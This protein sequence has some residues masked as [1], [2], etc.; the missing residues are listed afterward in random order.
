MPRRDAENG[1]DRTM[2]RRTFVAGASALG[3]T[4]GALS[5]AA[6][7][8]SK[9]ETGK[10]PKDLSGGLPDSREYLF[11]ERP[12]EPEMRDAVNVWIEEE[13]G[14]FG[15][16]IGVESNS[17]RWDLPEI[18]L[19]VAFPDGRVMSRRSDEKAHSRLDRDGRP[20]ILGA[21]PLRF[22]LIKPFETWT[23]AFDGDAAEITAQELIE[24]PYPVEK[25]KRPVSFEIT[26]TMAVPPWVA[27]AMMLKEQAGE[28]EK[29]A[30]FISP[31]FEQLC[32]CEG[33]MTI[34]DQAFNVKGQGLRV[35][36]QGLRK[37]SN[38][39][40]HVW[41]SCLFPSGKAFGLNTFGTYKDERP[42][43][44]EAFYYDGETMTPAKIL[45][46]PWMKSLAPGGD[47]VPARLAT[48]SG[49]VV[50]D[51]VTFVNCRSR[52]PAALPPGFAADYPVI[53]QSHAKY[54]MGG[55]AATGMIERSTPP[56]LLA[57]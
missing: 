31:R 13:N 42:S 46:V 56:R 51:G 21:G 54:R 20:A 8:A 36:R 41:Q 39:P 7:A 25:V 33:R 24:T 57:K 38:F 16:R 22:Q 55:E 49:E 3:V 10:M 23:V 48:P 1:E 50:I 29:A 37:F 47:S 44:G 26:M 9:T 6:S 27:G 53:Q 18:Y 34:G 19:D 35:R 11:A 32:R 5:S 28:F 2:D 14:A 12:A 52:Y 43:Y 17:S 45:Q 40:G 30:Q 15:M 4:A